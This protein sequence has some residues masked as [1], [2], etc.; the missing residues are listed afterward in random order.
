MAFDYA[1]KLEARF[2]AAGLRAYTDLSSERMNA[3]IRK[4]QQMKVP[5]QVIVGEKEMNDDLGKQLSSLHDQGRTFF[6]RVIWKKTRRLRLL[7]QLTDVF[8]F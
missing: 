8:P 2:R 1:S 7:R 4:A 5:Y 6:E 3:K